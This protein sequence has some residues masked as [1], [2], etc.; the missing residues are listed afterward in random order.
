M[1][2]V[3]PAR[4]REPAAWIMLAVVCPGVLIGVWYFVEALFGGT[5]GGLVSTAFQTQASATRV[6]LAVGAVV[7]TTRFGAPTPQSRLIAL[8]SVGAL[9]LSVVFGL[10]SGLLMLFASFDFGDKIIILLNS[11]PELALAAI[12]G[13]Y[14][15]STIA[16]AAAKP[17][18]QGRPQERNEEPFFGGY[19]N[20]GFQG[21]GSYPSPE[22]A[23]APVPT[24]QVPSV[25][26]APS[27]VPPQPQPS[28]QPALPYGSAERPADRTQDAYAAPVYDQGY[29]AQP[30]FVQSPEQVNGNGYQPPVYAAA[31]Q[32][33]PQQ[34]PPQGPVFDQHGYAGDSPSFPPVAYNEPTYAEPVYS[35]PVYKEP[36]YSEQPAYQEPAYQ[37]P[38]YQEPA[39]QEP[40]YQP[41][42]SNYGGSPFSGYSG[43]QFAQQA[44]E[45]SYEGD[46]REQQLAQAYQQAQSYQQTPTA[47]QQAPQQAPQPVYNNP[48]GHPQTREPYQQ[49]RF[50]GDP[51]SGPE[52]TVRYQ[53]DP[54][55]S[56]DQGR[57][58]GDPLSGP[59]RTRFQGD[60]L[61]DPLRGDEL[62]DPTAIYKP[63]R[64]Q[65]KPEE[66]TSREQA[67]QGADGNPHWYGSDRRD[68]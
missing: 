67:A 60:P 4:L 52:Q 8:I 14:I 59:E 34:Q 32:A 2:K 29:A 42:Q 9:A 5:L 11:L 63:E 25:S 53:G 45:P 27:A 68:H 44:Y 24:A 66:G 13:V 21:Y 22:P 49:D 33:F 35:E 54:L 36:T 46:L 19:Q 30:G 43:Q 55:S 18:R 47:P 37:E 41:N 23:G 10:L 40:T 31:P 20:D 26:T 61:T 28:A 64:Q 17:A 58:L 6:A 50:Q 51:L 39:Y 3:E 48:L 7:L 62:L 15:L 57:Y 1:I 16:P 65:A 56:P 12:A 38:A